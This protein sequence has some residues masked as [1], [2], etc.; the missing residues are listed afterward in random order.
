MELLYDIGFFWRCF[1]VALPVTFIIGK[2]MRVGL[3]IVLVVFS[4]IFYEY[5]MVERAFIALSA[6]GLIQTNLVKAS[7]LLRYW[8]IFALWIFLL[9]ISSKRW[10]SKLYGGFKRLAQLGQ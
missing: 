5:K 2:R 4:L 9:L 8:I 3:V 6:D 7:S 1:L 10:A